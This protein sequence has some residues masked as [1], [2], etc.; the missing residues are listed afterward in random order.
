[1]PL[2]VGREVVEHDTLA[3]RPGPGKVP[4][5]L[6]PGVGL[7]DGQVLAEGEV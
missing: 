1:M 3:F 2:A 5:V 4:E 6:R 7:I